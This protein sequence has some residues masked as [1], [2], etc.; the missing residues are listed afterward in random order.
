[1]HS[2]QIEG[3]IDRRIVQDLILQLQCAWP[4]LALVQLNMLKCNILFYF[5][6]YAYVYIYNTTLCKIDISFGL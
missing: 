6:K 5:L 4:L 2:S 1:M 3:Q